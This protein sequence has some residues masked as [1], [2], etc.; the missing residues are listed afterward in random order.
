MVGGCARSEP[1]LGVGF[2]PLIFYVDYPTRAQTFGDFPLCNKSPDATTI[3]VTGLKLTDPTSGLVVDGWGWS[4][5]FGKVHG[6]VDKS[7]KSLSEL[8]FVTKPVEVKMDCQ[9]WY[10][11]PLPLQP[12]ESPQFAVRMH[13]TGTSDEWSKNGITVTY[14][15]N[16]TPM[17]S[18]FA[19]MYA[20]CGATTPHDPALE[21]CSP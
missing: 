16:G 7:D 20:F 4:Y 9:K 12:N 6:I 2:N 21:Y 5:S 14:L 10:D 3:V 15:Q 13:A 18:T 1:Q 19:Y 11:N 17:E 8:G